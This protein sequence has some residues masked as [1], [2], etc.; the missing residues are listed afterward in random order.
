[1]EERE[2][3][4]RWDGLCSRD[5]ATRAAALD[6]IGQAVLRRSETVA[7]VAAVPPTRA[8][9]G[10]PVPAARDGLSEVLARLLMLSKRCPFPDVR[11]KSE[12]ILGEVQELGIRIPR[13]LGHGPSRFIPEKETIQVGNE[14]TMMHTLFADTFA[15]LGRLDNVTLVMVFHPQ[16]LESFLK[17]QHYLLQMDGPLPLHYRHYIGIMAAARHQCSYLVNLHVNDF[18]HVGGDP[19]WLNG[20]ENAPQKLQNLG[21]LNKML[22]HRPWLITKEHIEQLLKT[23][24]N[25]WSLAE[26]I[27]AVVLLTHYH[28]LA[29]FTFGCGISPEIDCEGGHTFRPPSVSN[30]CICD[31][32]NGYHGVD[33]IHA[34]PTGSIPSTESVCEVEALMEKMKQLQECRDEEEASQEEMATR[35][36]REKRESM[37]VCSSEDEESAPSRDVSRHFE[38]T[39]YGYKDFSRHGMHVPT[40]RVQDYSWEDHGYS[41]VNRLYPDVGQLLDEK[42]HIAY[43]LTYNTMATH[44]DVD[45]SM[46]RRAI[47]NYIHCMFGIRYD[48][49]D[50]GE[51]NQLLDRSFKVYIKTVVCTPEKTTKR[52][53]DSFWRQFEHSE[54]VHV[55]LLLVEARM[56]AELLYALR[57]ITRYMT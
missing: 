26:L 51:I 50:Y 34:S 32:T 23:E 49:Y 40:F 38:D 5:A 35:F 18:L 53:Y 42:F 12:E 54:K 25:S 28:S 27:H 47:W 29:S 21:E 39:S 13:P 52:M 36:E 37:F 14:D 2:G 20:L 19:K 16:Y 33:E 56:Q 10:L 6:T 11:E 3:E 24:E 8:A 1:M 4:V 9:D 15:M 57:A 44:K 55:N 7:P 41:L 45:T 48:D 46:L 43:N 30:Y 31:I 22:A 17:T